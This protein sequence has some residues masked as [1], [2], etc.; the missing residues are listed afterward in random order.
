MYN[1][2]HSYSGHELAI[3]LEIHREY[4][5]HRWSEE[6]L[7]SLHQRGSRS[8]F[9]S[10]GNGTPGLVGHK[11]YPKGWGMKDPEKEREREFMVMGLMYM[12]LALIICTL[13]IP[14]LPLVIVDNFKKKYRL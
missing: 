11:S 13:C 3:F 7:C 4:T 5:G 8:I 2:M 1:D 6:S 9:H 12:G 10:V 14:M